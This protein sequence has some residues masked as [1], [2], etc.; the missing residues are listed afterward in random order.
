MSETPTHEQDTKKDRIVKVCLTPQHAAA[1][2][3]LT[4]DVGSDM[5]TFTRQLIIRSLREAQ[6]A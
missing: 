2:K 6:A 1:F 5:S 4:K 3:A